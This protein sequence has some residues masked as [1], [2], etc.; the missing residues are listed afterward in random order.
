MCESEKFEEI[1]QLSEVINNELVHE[2]MYKIFEDI[3][4]EKFNCSIINIR[5]IVQ[6]LFLNN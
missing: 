3:D 5:S 6:R 2:N 4:L 1:L